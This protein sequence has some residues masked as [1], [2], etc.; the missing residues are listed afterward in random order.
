VTRPDLH[1]ERLHLQPLTREHTDVLVDLDS[2]PEVLR[3]I[4]GR[5]LTR[6]EVVGTWMP[7]RTRADA[8]AR[9]LGYW[10]GSAGGEFLGW[11]CLGVDDEDPSAAELG[12]RLRRSAWGRGYATEGG[13][14]LVDHGFER[15]GLDL[16]WGET[17][18]VNHASRHVLAK[19]GLRH[20]STEVRQWD[21]PLP[22][23]EKGEV[24][25]ALTR[26]EWAADA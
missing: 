1:T 26:D 21:D 5:A 12:Y 2:D 6:A 25:Y 8:D 13:R 20:V 3:F 14:A 18:A 15:V 11:W 7:K 22:G 10:V 16:I 17:M 24:R 4:F 19:C 9:G 23:W